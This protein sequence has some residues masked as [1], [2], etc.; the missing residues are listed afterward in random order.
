MNRSRTIVI[1]IALA[2][3]AAVPY[4]RTARHAFIDFDDNQYIT[5]NSITPRGLTAEGIAWAFTT[6]KASNW[7]PITWLSH[8]VDCSLFVQG[9]G[10]QWAGGHHLVNVLIHLLNTLLVFGVLQ[11]LTKAPWRSALVAGLF[12]VHPL[13]VESVAWIAERKD[14]LSTMF[15]LLAIMGYVGYVQRP[16]LARYLLIV[17]LFGLSLMSKPMLVTLPCVLLLLDYWPLGRLRF[18]RSGSTSSDKS[19]SKSK[20]TTLTHPSLS[21]IVL[22]KLPLLAMSI[23]SSVITVIAQKT[24]GSVFALEQLPVPQRIANAAV[25]YATYLGKTIWP[26]NLAIIYSHPGTWPALVVAGSAA[27][28]IVVTVMVWVLRRKR[29]HLLMGWL[30]FL[31]TLVPVIGLVQVGSQSMADRYMYVPMIGLLVM[32]AWSIPDPARMSVAGVR[33]VTAAAILAI[34]ALMAQTALQV[35]RWKDSVT[36]FSHAV[37]VT[38]RNYVAHNLLGGV[39]RQKGDRDGAQ[40]QLGA[41]LEL[42]PNYPDAHS[43]MGLLMLDTAQWSKAEEHF[44]KSLSFRPG[45]GVTLSNLG[46]AFFRQNRIDE[47][48]TQFRNALQYTP[49]NVEALVNLGN[50]YAAKGNPDQAIAQY[51]AALAIR[52]DLAEAHASI[53]AIE[54]QRKNLAASI[55]H[56]T[57]A[58]KSRPDMIEVR[59]R[60]GF[61][62]ASQNRLREAAEQLELVL[63]QNPK[64]ELARQGLDMIRQE[65]RR[66]MGEPK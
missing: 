19:K 41:S 65:Q 13:H 14:V 63:R 42:H 28:L 56:D 1:L 44:K 38:D 47:A 7:H 46:V 66:I 60:L 23:G 59:T 31:G 62:L 5:E 29:P 17:V 2:A 11:A 6:T 55:T 36:L 51:Q 52:P 22:E 26:T 37:A 43:N 58:L 39:L 40:R 54:F 24:G 64:H 9:D 12:A 15:G 25:A 10:R 53:A 35:G 20:S 49:A 27:V 8:M 61:A 45:D 57:L 34:A 48:I 3:I 18:D 4:A 32:I 30:W 16:S 21:Q 50:T 33:A